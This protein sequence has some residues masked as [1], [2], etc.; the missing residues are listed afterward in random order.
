M[1]QFKFDWDSHLLLG[2][3]DIDEQH[4]RLFKIGRDIE[5]YIMIHCIGVTDKQ[6]LDILY[7]L[8]DYVT[9]HFY[10][11]EQ[12]MASIDYPD[13][14]HHKELHDNFKK[15]INQIDYAKLCH[16]PKEELIVLKESLVTWIFEHM[17][18]EDSRFATFAQQNE[19]TLQDA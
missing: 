2:I 11:E 13:L 5:Q 1:V 19:K 18:H 4:K 16:S 8:R 10:T 9:Y 15:Y 17:I 7:E 14:A 3:D 6:L 12:Y